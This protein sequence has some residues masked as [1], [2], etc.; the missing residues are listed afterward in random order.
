MRELDCEYYARRRRECL[1]RAAAASDETIAC[2]HREFAAAYENRLL[3]Q[4]L[5]SPVISVW[6]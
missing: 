3:E 5:D 6:N 1:A 2:V 4:A